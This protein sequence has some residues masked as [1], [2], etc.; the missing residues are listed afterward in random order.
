MGKVYLPQ[1]LYRSIQESPLYIL[2][3][4]ERSQEKR[5]DNLMQHYGIFPAN[6]LKAAI[7]KIK[8]RLGDE[9]Y[10]NILERLYAGNLREVCTNLLNYYDRA[11][12]RLTAQRN[13]ELVYR[14][15]I[16]ANYSNQ[17]IAKMI[18]AYESH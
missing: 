13:Q 9:M 3:F 1:Q 7:H 10:R 18:I 5:V 16:P 14:I 2:Y 17:E 11:Y 6:E 12:N 15:P 4:I 8:K